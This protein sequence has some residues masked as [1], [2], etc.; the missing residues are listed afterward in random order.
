MFLLDTD[1]IIYSLKDNEKVKKNLRHHYH[2]TIKISV[3]T[4]MELYYGAYKSRKIE[5]NLAKIKTLENSLE[6]LSLGKESVELFGTYKARL[7]KNGLPLDDFD[8]MIASIALTHNLILVTN[9]IRHFK[10][11]ECLK[12]MN[13][14]EYPSSLIES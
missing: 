8:I 4:L 3:V 6:I 11:I 10:R 12:M 1:T 9:N 14:T 2:E 13:W 7:E 5:S